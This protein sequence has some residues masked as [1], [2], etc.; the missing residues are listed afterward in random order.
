MSSAELR[1]AEGGAG[2]QRRRALP[3]AAGPSRVRARAGTRGE[4]EAEGEGVGRRAEGSVQSARR[5]RGGVGGGAGRRR[6][7][8][9]GWL[10]QLNAQQARS[11]RRRRALG[12]EESDDESGRSLRL[13]A[14]PARAPFPSRARRS[15]LIHQTLHLDPLLS[16][17]SLLSRCSR[18]HE[19]R[20]RGATEAGARM[21]LARQLLHV[22]A[23]SLSTTLDARTRCR[24]TDVAG[25]RIGGE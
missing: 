24:R 19:R 25:G 23:L 7:C 2:A 16:T 21:R 3:R 6:R 4:G 22:L 15:P 12:G 9:P 14:R 11:G 10:A 13:L 5:R 17:C 8:S 18:H 1:R 20:S